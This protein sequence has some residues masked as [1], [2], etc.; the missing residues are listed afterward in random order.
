MASTEHISMITF[1][2]IF[3]NFAPRS[4]KSAPQHETKHE[5]LKHPV[6]LQMHL[7][8]SKLI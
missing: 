5:E 1:N 8:V 6:K 4:F 2:V 7:A 3:S